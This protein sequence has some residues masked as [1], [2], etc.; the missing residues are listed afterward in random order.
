MKEK[1]LALW[2]QAKTFAQEHQTTLI[3]AGTAVLGAVVGGTIVALATR[4]DEDEMVFF[5]EDETP[6][7]ETTDDEDAELEDEAE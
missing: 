6:D 2:A 4:E 3:A 5:D 1:L 7:V